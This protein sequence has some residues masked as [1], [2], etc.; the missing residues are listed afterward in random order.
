MDMDE[1]SE[2]NIYSYATIKYQN[3]MCWPTDHDL[4]FNV[5]IYTV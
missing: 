1:G 4:L 5:Y 3:L 2:Q